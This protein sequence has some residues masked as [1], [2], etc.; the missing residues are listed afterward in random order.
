MIVPWTCL[1]FSTSN[2]FVLSTCPSGKSSTPL[3]I[4]P[5]Q[6]H[7]SFIQHQ[8]QVGPGPALSQA[9]SQPGLPGGIHFLSVKLLGASSPGSDHDFPSLT[10]TVVSYLG[11]GKSEH[12]TP[13]HSLASSFTFENSCFLNAVVWTL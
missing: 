9:L 11:P 2:P 5:N 10:L 3:P 12:F 6:I 7:F 1:M 4:Q 8:V 13:E